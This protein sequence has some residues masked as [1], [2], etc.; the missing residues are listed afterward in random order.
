MPRSSGAFLVL[1]ILAALTGLLLAA[2]GDGGRQRT[3]LPSCEGNEHPF[4]VAPISVDL[5]QAIRP[6]GT[7]NPPS[8]TFP[9]QHTYWYAKGAF[10]SGLSVLPEV[11]DV[12]APGQIT[13]T[14]VARVEFHDR[15]YRFDYSVDFAPCD[16]I[17]GWFG[18]LSELAPELI[19]ALEPFDDCSTRST[20]DESL[21]ECFS[22]REVQLAPGD[23]I[24]R[25]GIYGNL[26]FGT[27][28]HRVAH[29]FANPE[30]VPWLVN[31]T[32]PVDYFTPAVQAELEPL[33]GAFDGA[34]PRTVEPVCGEVSYD[35]PGTAAGVWVLEDLPEGFVEGYGLA[36]ARDNVL[37][38]IPAVSIGNIGTAL[39]GAVLH[40]VTG[41][42]E[43]F[44]AVK[45]DGAVHCYDAVPASR[46]E[47][48]VPHRVVLSLSDEVLR[49]AVDREVSCAHGQALPSQHVR[50]VR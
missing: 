3:P 23:R 17:Y 19:A 50:M 49:F 15:D 10:L 25:A 31:I 2:C 28:D 20:A 1:A 5:L 30:R 22:H 34:Y 29:P 21:T 27:L 43:P 12:V 37:A 6:L 45:D 24:G 9:T 8:H 14:R 13:L 32:C 40:V 39:D 7:L 11:P 46:F 41:V 18:H 26:D 42:P 38:D 35:R 16:E 47:Q 48:P 36:L 33:L 4:S 44:A